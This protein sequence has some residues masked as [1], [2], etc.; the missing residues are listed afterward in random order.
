VRPGRRA[1]SQLHV[2][3]F[4][5]GA[6]P[7]IASIPDGRSWPAPDRGCIGMLAA[8]GLDVH[9]LGQG[10]KEAGLPFGL[11]GEDGCVSRGAEV[12]GGPQFH[13]PVE[14]VE[15]ERV[16]FPAGAEGGGQV[17]IAGPVDLL[18]PGAE[19]GKR[20]FTF[21]TFELPPPG[22]AGGLARVAVPPAVAGCR[23]AGQLR[24]E[25]SHL[26]VES[27]ERTEDGRLP[28]GRSVGCVSTVAGF[29][30]M[31][32]QL[33]ET[34]CDFPVMASFA[35]VEDGEALGVLGDLQQHG[36]NRVCRAPGWRAHLRFIARDRA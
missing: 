2:T 13:E 26:L 1:H 4:I 36:R 25:A 14:P 12:E 27:V 28:C 3:T 6:Q 5:A 23:H 11:A 16:L 18:D 19:A 31:S 20:L 9:L 22:S 33:S 17:A 30:E 21:I 24:G 15:A 32:C 29:G 10:R 7:V 34:A 35:F 8:G